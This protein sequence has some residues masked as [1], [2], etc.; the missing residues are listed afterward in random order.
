MVTGS[1]FGSNQSD[2][3]GV[4]IS[5]SSN[6]T[7][8]KGSRKSFGQS[9]DK[10]RCQQPNIECSAGKQILVIEGNALTSGTSSALN[11]FV[12]GIFGGQN[13]HVVD[14][15]VN[16]LGNPI[17]T[18]ENG[19]YYNSVGTDD[20]ILIENETGPG[21]VGSGNLFSGGQHWTYTSD[22]VI[23]GE[24]NICSGSQTFVP[25]VSPTFGDQTGALSQVTPI[26]CGS[27][28]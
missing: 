10:S 8:G 17:P 2:L 23:D 4:F 27:G 15:A 19:S 9:H 21:S 28:N 11:P 5:D 20:D 3:G 18:E 6:V 26:N 13:T 7:F 25:S 22:D 1:T 16:G 12:I 24:G 14:N